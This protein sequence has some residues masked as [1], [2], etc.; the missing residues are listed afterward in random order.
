MSRGSSRGS[1]RRSRR[2]GSSCGKK[3]RNNRRSY[4]RLGID[5]LGEVT[6]DNDLKI[7]L[8][9]PHGATSVMGVGQCVVSM[10][11]DIWC[12]QVVQPSGA[13]LVECGLWAAFLV[14]VGPPPD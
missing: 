3:G 6:D 9:N 13:V 5:P 8:Y 1:R 7:V 14:L 11:Q 12:F 2:S 4:D 10:V